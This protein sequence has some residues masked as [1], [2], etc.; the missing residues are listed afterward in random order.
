MVNRA[1][2]EY[3]LRGARLKRDHVYVLANGKPL[4]IA[5]GPLGPAPDNVLYARAYGVTDGEYTLTQRDV[6]IGRKVNG[7]DQ[8]REG[9]W[10]RLDANQD[11]DGIVSEKLA[12]YQPGPL[13]TTTAV[14]G[15]EEVRQELSASLNKFLEDAETGAKPFNLGALLHGPPGTGKTTIARQVVADT[16]VSALTIDA[17]AVVSTKWI[18]EAEQRLISAFAECRETGSVLVLDEV[19][20]VG[21]TRGENQHR[22]TT[23][24]MLTELAGMVEKTP[25]YVIAT[26][27]R[28]DLLDTALLR[29][30]RIGTH[31]SVGLPTASDRE[32]LIR[33]L[34]AR[35]DSPKQLMDSLVERTAGMTTA[36]VAQLLIDLPSGQEWTTLVRRLDRLR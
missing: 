17:P 7:F 32:E 15:Y 28:A 10:L 4:E 14:F 18:G 23:D 1:G 25:V 27:N 8:I 13:E 21:S 16:G 2:I 6:A 24:V 19:E 20:A 33:G 29:P 5:S 22:E 36:E 34:V 3:F 11:V 12:E 35:A 30:G 31:I 26:T 9:Q